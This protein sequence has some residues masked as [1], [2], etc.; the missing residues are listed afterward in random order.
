MECERRASATKVTV[1]PGVIRG[2]DGVM[3]GKRPVLVF[4]DG[5]VDYRTSVV[6]APRYDEDAVARALAADFEQHGAPLVCRMDRAKCHT[7]PK[8]LKVLRA[9][10]VLVLQGPPHFP[11]YY[12]QLE[13]Q[14][15]EHRQWLSALGPLASDELA[16]ACEQMRRAFNELVPRRRLGWQT[17]AA[18]WRGSSM[19]NVNRG[20][21]AAEVDER[22][23]RLEEDEAVRCGH[24]GLAGRLA[25]EAALINRGLLKLTKG[26]WC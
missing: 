13:R 9:H 14:N 11:R 7:A 19:P 25:I 8:V 18:V 5:A 21:L 3:L 2:F 12:G 24:P 20:E 16:P 15:R 17:A 6:P 23:K 26:G 4:A 10:K 22:R 1:R